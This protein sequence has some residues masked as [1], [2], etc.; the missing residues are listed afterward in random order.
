VTTDMSLSL[1]QLGLLPHQVE[2]VESAL[3]SSTPARFVLAD[4]VGLGKTRAG[5]ALAWAISR[6]RQR[7]IRILVIAPSALVGQWTDELT[8]LNMANAFAVDAQ[9]FRRLEARTAA[10]QN[11]WSAVETAVTSVDFVK[12]RERPR[13]LVS[14]G[15]DL[16]IFDEVRISSGES[17]R[18]QLL[19]SL[20]GDERVLLMV[21]MSATL[22]AQHIDRLRVPAQHVFRRTARDL[23]DWDGR[24]IFPDTLAVEVLRIELSSE[25][26]ELLTTVFKMLEGPSLGNEPSLSFAA[27]GLLDR[28]SSSLFAF[29][30]SLRRALSR[31]ATSSLF[32]AD[33]AEGMEDFEL[34]DAAGRPDSPATQPIAPLQIRSLLELI[35]RVPVDSKWQSCARILLAKQANSGRST[36][37][38]SDFADTAEYIADQIRLL[39]VAIPVGI[40]IGATG[41]RER[42]AAVE[43]VREAGGVLAVTSSAS[44]GLDLS[45]VD[46]CVHYDV[47]RDAAA[48]AQRVGRIHRVAGPTT[49]VRQIAFADEIL[50]SE[51]T[52]HMMFEF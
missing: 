9:E 52:L 45:F 31:V 26:R 27:K 20:W 49:P 44:A 25:E 34:L 24:R 43:H 19:Q 12:E 35:E 42:D 29:E 10:N 41:F 21:A 33:G 48:L 28:A 11:P 17:Q 40:V 46:T 47:P 36:V 51:A 6:Q 30:Q 50:T 4:A 39:D 3:A 32:Q 5:A 7:P 23:L 13:S 1:R 38:F 8:S 15:W 37:I 14:A 18:D 2:F 22:P 16:V